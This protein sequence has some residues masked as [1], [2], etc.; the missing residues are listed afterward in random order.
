MSNKKLHFNAK[1]VYLTL[2]DN[3]IRTQE[4]CDKFLNRLCMYNNKN[5]QGYVI[6]NVEKGE[7]GQLH[8]HVFVKG[9]HP[10]EFNSKPYIKLA[11]GTETRIHYVPASDYTNRTGDITRL[12]DYI[13]K[14]GTA[15][16]GGS[17]IENPAKVSW[18]TALNQAMEMTDFN[19]ATQF[20]MQVN[21]EKFLMQSARIHLMWQ[22][23]HKREQDVERIM[24]VEYNDW[25]YKN[26]PELKVIN[27]WVG[28]ASKQSTKRIPIMFVIGPT[29]TGKTSYV[30]REVY[31]KYNSFLM[32]GDYGWEEYDQQEDYKFYILDD[33]NFTNKGY[34]NQ[35][36]A[37]TSTRDGVN[38]IK[39]LYSHKMVKS[40]PCM[41]LL[42]DRE[43]D[44]VLNQMRF[45][46]GLEWWNKNSIAVHINKKLYLTNAEMEVK[47]DLQEE[48]ID[49][50]TSVDNVPE[51]KKP[52]V[53][54]DDKPTKKLTFRDRVKNWFANNSIALTEEQLNRLDQNDDSLDQEEEDDDELQEEDLKYMRK[55]YNI[56]KDIDVDTFEPP[57][58]R[59]YRTQSRSYNIAYQQPEEE[60]GPMYEDDE[61]EYEDEPIEE[62]EGDNVDIYQ[63]INP[64]EQEDEIIYD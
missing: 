31:A 37:I 18:N 30:E 16:Q 9:N 52:K 12:V 4:D 28:I 61:I 42:N 57:R 29:K 11:D 14:S 15:F 36:K 7:M 64:Y 24:S 25:D 43:W 26:N 54:D 49:S 22:T 46:G 44:R 50:D 20:L 55:E 33:V 27:R 58:K 19:E 56:E 6:G 38:R 5:I 34:L 8:Q 63:Q 41:I 2:F 3:F 45:E 32:R 47:R 23:R 35:L 1:N 39:V 53:I 10:L 13:K 48:L 62:M 59:P 17:I 51:E 40:K 21:A 60:E